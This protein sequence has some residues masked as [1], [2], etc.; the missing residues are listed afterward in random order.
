[1]FSVGREEATWL[2][3]RVRSFVFGDR[4]MPEIDVG[5]AG[6]CITLSLS[7]SWRSALIEPPIE[8]WSQTYLE[9][10]IEECNSSC[11]IMIGVA[12]TEHAC[13]NLHDRARSCM[14]ECSR[15]V[16]VNA[17]ESGGK[18]GSVRG[19]RVAGDKVGVLLDAQNF[20]VFV[21]GEPE[22]AASVP[23]TLPRTV[24][25]AVEAFQNAK[26]RI[27]LGAKPPLL[28]PTPT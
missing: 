2:K 7:G 13:Y 21:N 20:K 28:L 11:D 14:F 15:G 12:A 23:M 6:N 27:V 22:P 18:A 25:F 19:K 5:D 3:P 16:I 17:E 24:R 1:M 10:L 26:V 4:R 8:T 9:F